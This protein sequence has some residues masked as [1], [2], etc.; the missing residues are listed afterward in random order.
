[1]YNQKIIVILFLACH[2]LVLSAFAQAQSNQDRKTLY[3]WDFLTSDNKQD[4]LTKKLT[5]EFE[6][7]LI[8]AR[9]YQVLERR[10]YDRVVAH[11]ENE[12]KIRSYDNFVVQSKADQRA[13]ATNTV[14]MGTMDDDVASGEVKVTVIFQRLDSTNDDKRSVRIKR[15]LINDAA[16]R[17]K[18]MKDLVSEICPSSSITT[19]KTPPSLNG[20]WEQYIAKPTGS[21]FRLIGTFIVTKDRN[22]KL[23]IVT[24][25]MSP[26]AI[27]SLGIHG[28]T[29]DGE[30][31]TFYSDWSS[32]QTAFFKLRRVSDNVFEGYSSVGGRIRD[33]NRWI[34]V[35]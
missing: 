6:E 24:K 9:C 7:A 13:V 32:R 2:C 33:R 17:E 30:S 8:Q 10:R 18:A 3:V 16:S 11:Q 31:W 22:D 35:E 5:E 34:K 14:V 28:I 12:K 20:I 19:K 1:M 26:N 23:F 4:S 29:Y 21:D 27:Q 25:E 15:G